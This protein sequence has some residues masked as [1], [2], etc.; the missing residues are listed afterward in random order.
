MVSSKSLFALD[1]KV[2]VVVVVVVFVVVVVDVVVVVVFVVVVVVN[3]DVLRF[4]TR[5]HTFGQGY[6]PFFES[7]GLLANVM[8]S[9]GV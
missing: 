3:H 1:S 6:D 2:N 4:V 9:D 8:A 7:K 5:P